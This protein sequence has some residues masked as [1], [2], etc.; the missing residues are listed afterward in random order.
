MK[1]L[2][3]TDA[4]HAACLRDVCPVVETGI[5]SKTLLDTNAVKVV[6]FAMDADQE[7]SEHTSPYLTIIHMIDEHLNLVVDGQG[8]DLGSDGWLVIPAARSHALVARE[9]TCF[10]LTLVKESAP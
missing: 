8:F 1:P 7:L 5:V 2:F 9:P 6:E 4:P 3:D 10:L